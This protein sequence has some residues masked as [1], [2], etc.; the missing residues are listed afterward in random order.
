MAD[1]V[2]EE[3]KIKEKEKPIGKNK[4]KKEKINPIAGFEGITIDLKQFDKKT[5]NEQQ[6][7]ILNV[8]KNIYQDHLKVTRKHVFKVIKLTL[9]TKDNY[10]Y[11]P[12]NL[13]VSKEGLELVFSVERKKDVP[14][15]WI[16]FAVWTFIFALIAATYTGVMY[17]S[18]ADL[19]KDIDGDGIPDINIDINNDRK[20]E[21]NVDTDDDDKPNLNIDYKGNRKAIFNIDAD[22]DGVPD[23]NLVFDASVDG[24]KCTI[25]C[26]TNNDG[27]PDIN[28]DLDGDGIPDTDIDTDGDLVADL[29]IDLNGD[30]IC[31]VMCDTD[32]DGKCDVNCIKNTEPSKKPGTSQNNGD[33]E[34]IQGTATII[35]NFIEGETINIA[36]LVPDDQPYYEGEERVNPRK[37]FTI[38][39][40][41]TYAAIY[42]LKWKDLQNTFTS[43]NFKFKLDGTNGAPSFGYK[44]APKEEDYIVKDILIPA[45][46]SQKYVLTFNLEGVNGPQ[47]YDQNKTFTAKVDVEL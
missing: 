17:L 35:I 21:I 4:K 18:L 40:I 37:T 2:K 26:D 29:N 1:K 32:N 41:G 46:T 14:F 28:V 10:I 9:N 27:W 30:N 22:G 16:I 8:L 38:E 15:G 12:Y 19:N 33:P 20:A 24:A 44:V 34:T 13:K 43:D 42:S 39:N 45:K 11:L 7:E 23:F 31:D 5:S 36:N 3:N 6:E 47:N 25:N